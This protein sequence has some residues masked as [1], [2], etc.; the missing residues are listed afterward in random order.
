M[1]GDSYR[2][3]RVFLPAVLI[4]GPALL[5]LRHILPSSISLQRLSILQPHWETSCLGWST[6]IHLAWHDLKIR[7]GLFWAQH[8]RY[9]TSTNVSM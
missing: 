7:L 6:R 5:V 8:I 9:S 4:P 1:H 2:L 3:R